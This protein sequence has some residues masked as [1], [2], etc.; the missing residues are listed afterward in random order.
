MLYDED[1]IISGPCQLLF[2]FLYRELGWMTCC[3]RMIPWSKRSDGGSTAICWGDLIFLM[4]A[5]WFSRALCFFHLLPTNNLSRSFFFSFSSFSLPLAHSLFRSRSRRGIRAIASSSLGAEGIFIRALSTKWNFH[6]SESL[7]AIASAR[8]VVASLPISCFKASCNLEIC[9]P[10]FTPQDISK[11]EEEEVE[12]SHFP[13]SIFL[14]FLS[15][16][17]STPL[18]FFFKESSRSNSSAWDAWGLS[19]ASLHWANP[20]SI[21]ERQIPTPSNNPNI[22]W[23]PSPVLCSLF[24][25]HFL[26]ERK[27]AWGSPLTKQRLLFY[28]LSGVEY[29]HTIF[30]F[31]LLCFSSTTP[32]CLSTII[33]YGELTFARGMQLE[34]E[35][36][37]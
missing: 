27:T 6:S 9:T 28:I 33:F 2:V 31:S 8:Q 21:L 11:Q 29:V 34:L 30:C 25:C 24:S 5:L 14:H 1:T 7:P 18:V 15:Y 22:G 20:L 10:V 19:P 17:F 32:L 13:L 37:N 12:M 36:A 16:C 35:P 26:D 23:K 4:C 3:C